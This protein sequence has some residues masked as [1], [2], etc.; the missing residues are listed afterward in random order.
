MAVDLLPIALAE[1]AALKDML[2]PYLVEHADQVD[3]QRVHGD[4][5]SYDHFDP[6]WVDPAR[7]PYWIAADGERVGFCLVNA[8][9]PSGQAIDHAVAEFCILPAHRR[10]GLGRAAVGAVL[11]RHPG[12]WELQVYRANTGGLVFWP[13]AL[14]AA[15]V[16]ARQVLQREDRVIHRFLT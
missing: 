7:H 14:A 8:H 12:Q 13:R 6:Y 3:P 5:R 15:G 9:A 11:A 1:K 2:D 16:K 10:G 4:P